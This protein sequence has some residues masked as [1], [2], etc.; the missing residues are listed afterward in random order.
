MTDKPVPLVYPGPAPARRV[1][2]V[3]YIGPGS[4]DICFV[5]KYQLKNIWTYLFIKVYIG[6]RV[7]LSL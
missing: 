4:S 2:G 1:S 6:G 7:M 5:K 3:T